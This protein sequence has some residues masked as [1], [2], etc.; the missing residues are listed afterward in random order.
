MTERNTI[1]TQKKSVFIVDDHPL[2]REGLKTIINQMD[3]FA[4]VGEAGNGREAL[5]QI[6]QLKPSI[7]L[8]DMSLPDKNG[9]ELTRDIVHQVPKTRVMIISM[10]S[11]LDYIVKSF[12]SGALGYIVKESASDKLLRGLETVSHGDYFMD[13]AV[14]QKVINKLIALPEDAGIAPEAAYHT[15]TP[16]EQEIMTMVA[17]G[18]TSNEIA[19]R[20]FISPK[21]V[22]NHRS[23]IMR[24]LDVS[25]ALELV[26]YAARLGLID[27][28]LWKE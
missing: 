22:E 12:Q 14:S 6:R 10:H 28:D 21:T 8:V 16:R 2:F 5:L 15:L 4:V 13:T 26:R 20:L 11:K 18:F 25:S 1:L 27:L 17:E 24:K 19:T 7:A 23:S 9:I 3:Q